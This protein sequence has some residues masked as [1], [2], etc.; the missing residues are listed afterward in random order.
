[1]KK[2]K[3]SKT[4]NLLRN[5]IYE[6]EKETEGCTF[7][8]QIY[9]NTTGYGYTRYQKGDFFN[10]AILWKHQ[11]EVRLNQERMLKINKQLQECTFRPNTHCQVR[12]LTPLT[13]LLLP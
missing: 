11:K 2:L 6:Y 4:K 5:K 9:A 12:D 10:R 3:K 1:V 13:Y 8:P 7:H